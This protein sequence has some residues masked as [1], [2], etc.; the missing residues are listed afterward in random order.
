LGPPRPRAA[1]RR[2]LTARALQEINDLLNPN[3]NRLEVK[4]QITVS[5]RVLCLC[6]LCLSDDGARVRAH[7]IA[8]GGSTRIY[9]ADLTSKT[10]STPAEVAQLLAVGEGARGCR[11]V[12]SPLR[13]SRFA[14]VHAPA[15][16]R[17]QPQSRRHAHESR[18][19]ALAHHSPPRDR[20][21]AAQRLGTRNAIHGR[22]NDVRAPLG[23]Q[24]SALTI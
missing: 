8:Q 18:I 24:R 2:V 7:A 3:K 19:V 17:S 6:C 10:V 13:L 23:V 12:L 1:A 15:C 9:V 14:H 4:E 16:D 21:G 11:S 20:V 5:G 22:E